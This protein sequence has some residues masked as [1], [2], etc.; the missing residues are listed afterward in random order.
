M[1]ASPAVLESSNMI[2]HTRETAA[3]VH[4]LPARDL[5]PEPAWIAVIDARPCR[6]EFVSNFLAGQACLKGRVQ[7][8]DVDALLAER[9]GSATEPAMLIFSV[10]GLSVADPAVSTDFERLL[11]RFSKKP[12]VVLSDLDAR[13]EAQLALAAGA[14]GFVPT[15]L[16]PRLMCAALALIQTGGR[17]APPALFEEWLHAAHPARADQGE[18]PADDLV[19]QYDELT[20]RQTHVLHLLQ[21]GFANKVIATKLG[22]TESTVKVHV[23]QIMKRLGATNR[24]EAALL[25]QRHQEAL[26]RRAS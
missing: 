16:E 2:G 21:E 20:P 14:A 24:T 17:F 10:G 6:R 23:R 18:E 19:P 1:V 11:C 3:T 12:L 26:R 22:M 5:Q 8:I 13:D 15:L 7:P 4:A 9:G 25:A